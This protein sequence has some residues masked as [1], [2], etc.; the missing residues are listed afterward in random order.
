[1]IFHNLGL[2]YLRGENLIAAEENFKKAIDVKEHIDTN[3][4][5]SCSDF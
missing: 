5:K 3:G 4:F 2:V 1:M